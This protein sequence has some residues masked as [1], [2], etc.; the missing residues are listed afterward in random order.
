MPT[1]RF[2]ILVTVTYIFISI[3]NARTHI[4]YALFSDK[5]FVQT[6]IQTGKKLN[7]KVFLNCKAN[8]RVVSLGS[9]CDRLA[10]EPEAGA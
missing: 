4:H 3:I 9:I 2:R 6:I 5:I 10:G 7:L 8:E 1:K